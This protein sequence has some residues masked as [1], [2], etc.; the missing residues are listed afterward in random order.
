[1]KTLSHA[2]F[3]VV[4]PH[5][6][7]KSFTC[8]TTGAI[9]AGDLSTC[10][11]VVTNDAAI[12]HSDAYDAMLGPFID[13][14]RQRMHKVTVSGLSSGKYS[15]TQSDGYV[16]ITRIA[17]GDTV[18]IVYASVFRDEIVA[19]TKLTMAPTAVWTSHS[20]E[21]HQHTEPESQP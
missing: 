9:Q 10:T 3:D 20:G 7:L 5:L 15:P 13:T 14:D 16:N 11:M 21:E 4:E 8:D 1:M 12:S 18:T 17:V 6:T 19:S 2:S